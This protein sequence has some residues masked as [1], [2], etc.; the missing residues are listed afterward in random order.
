MT[1]LIYALGSNGSG[2]LGIGHDQ[3]VSI[4]RQVLF[5]PPGSEPSSPVVKVAAGGN[6][7][8]LLAADGKLYWAGDPTTG[9]C[10]PL[11]P[12]AA[13]PPA[14]DPQ[15]PQFAAQ[16]IALPSLPAEQG[17]AT[18]TTTTTAPVRLV[19][20]TWEASII[21][22]ADAQGRNSIVSTFGSGQKGELGQGQ[23]VIRTPTVSR[24]NDFPPRDTEVVDLSACMGHVV[25]ALS[26]GQVWGWGNG[27]KGQL[28]TGITG[29]VHEPQVLQGADFKVVRAVCGRE[30]TA[31]FGSPDRGEI[32]VLGADKAGVKS[33]A[34]ESIAGWKDVGA[35]WGGIYAL[36]GGGSLVSWGRDDHGQLAPPGLPGLQGVAIGSEH[37][38][39]LSQDG[40][41]LSWGW[42]EHG[43]CGP[44][45]DN[46]G[47]VRGR[48]NTIASQKYIPP[49]SKITAIG[50]GC[51]TSWVDIE[52]PSQP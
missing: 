1:H 3:D 18:T 38:V 12:P 41:V 22:Q 35:S 40:N 15:A 2:Q 17:S 21:V 11:T 47:D 36:T 8:L 6:H 49:G 4:P 50:A 32:L 52:L 29:I 19:A 26:N 42:G 28:G 30:F 13:T 48:W 7:S 14:D 34:P 23:F 25:V 24:L 9:A 45:V 37:V 16:E 46:K 51:A 44:Q 33:S 20:A 10:G 27:R 39:A 43:N 31:L 5:G